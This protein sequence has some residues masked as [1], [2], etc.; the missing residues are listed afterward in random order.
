MPITERARQQIEE[1][2]KGNDVVLFMKGNRNF[3]QCGFSAQVVQILNGHL[4]KYQ[5]V[6]VLSDPEIRD[7]IKDFSSWPTIPQLYVKGEF[8]GGCDIIKEMQATGELSKVLAGAAEAKAGGG[9]GA[10]A[11]GPAANAAPKVTMTADAIAAISKALHE[12]QAGHEG[13]NHAPSVL[14]LDVDPAFA[15]DLYFGDKAA[16]DFEVD[17]GSIKMYI[18]KES[19][20]RANGI[21]IAYVSTPDGGAFRIDNPNEPARVKSLSVTDVKQL[22]DAKTPFTF[23]DVRPENE[24][25]IA[26]LAEAQ[27]LDD[28]AYAKLESMDRKAMIVFHCHHGGRSRAAA[29]H[30]LREGF[31]NV[32]NMEGGI[33][34]W[35]QKIDAKIPRY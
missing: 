16:G 12:D 5:T 33:E 13:H 20:P 8:V 34:A 35:S 9:T 27:P 15:V 32:H 26:K 14:R 22:L 28:A 18:D 24:R 23:F 30:F 25:E 19:A 3:P 21:S 1:V 11:A 17:L 2:V 4:N 31:T 6:N 10:A 7:G 29:E